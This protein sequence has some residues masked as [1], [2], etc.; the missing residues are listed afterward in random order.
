MQRKD[1]Y[2][3]WRQ[4]WRARFLSQDKAALQRNLPYHMMFEK[5]SYSSCSLSAEFAGR[6]SCVKTSVVSNNRKMLY[7]FS[8]KR[9][10]QNFWRTCSKES[11]NH[12]GHTVFYACNCLICS[13]NFVNHVCI[14]FLSIICTRAD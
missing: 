1:N 11:A 9:I 13:H 8:Y 4:D 7:T 3:Q 6:L 5:L 10:H 2:E 14:T 12:D